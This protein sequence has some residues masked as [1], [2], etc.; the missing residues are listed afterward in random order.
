M[1]QILEANKFGFSKWRMIFKCRTW[2]WVEDELRH[3]V[4]NKHSLVLA[5]ADEPELEK[6][7]FAEKAE[8][9][10]IEK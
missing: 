7:D 10:D 2:T 4:V 3:K 8:I 5:G 1:N 6:W 9:P